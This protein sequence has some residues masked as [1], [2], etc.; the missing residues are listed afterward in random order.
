MPCQL[1]FTACGGDWKEG[2]LWDQAEL[3]SVLDSLA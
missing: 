2:G 3:G 1:C